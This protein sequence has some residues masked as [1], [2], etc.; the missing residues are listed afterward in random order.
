[1]L[2]LGK[3]YITRSGFPVTC[4]EVIPKTLDGYSLKGF[5]NNGTF[6]WTEE[7]RFFAPSTGNGDHDLDLIEPA[8]AGSAPN[9]KESV[10]KK[11]PKKVFTVCVS[12]DIFYDIPVEDVPGWADDIGVERL[13]ESAI[14]NFRFDKIEDFGAEG[15][16][17]MAPAE[18]AINSVKSA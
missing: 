9:L 5:V 17:K 7:G 11:E 13:L 4:L 8:I 15:H 12:V 1:M 18:I 16:L 10:M 6:Y 2:D 14:D 3:R